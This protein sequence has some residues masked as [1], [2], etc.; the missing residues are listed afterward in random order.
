MVGAAITG[1]PSAFGRAG[2]EDLGEA[3]ERLG[4]VDEIGDV[5]GLL[6]S[7]TRCHI[8][9]EQAFDQLR[10]ARR[11]CVGGHASEGHAHHELRLGGQ[12]GHRHVV[13]Q[14][15]GMVFLLRMPVGM[16]V[17]GKV[18]AERAATQRQVHGVPRVRVLGAAVPAH[19]LGLGV[20]LAQR[21]QR[22]TIGQRHRHALD[23]WRPGKGQTP[24]QGVLVEVGELV[25]HEVRSCGVRARHDHSLTEPA[26][27]RSA[28]SPPHRRW[29][30]RPSTTPSSG[31]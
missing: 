11:Q 16:T 13:G 19:H 7:G 31:C 17:P 2:L 21:P 1:E 27:T 6:R 29:T 9:N 15:V 5:L 22:P 28:G 8:D 14:L 18:N 20:A 4:A 23:R 25:L 26:S 10:V 24:L 12:L 3:R 30:N